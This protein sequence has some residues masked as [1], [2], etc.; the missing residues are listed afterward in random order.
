MHLAAGDGAAAWEAHETA[1]KLTG[2]DPQLA[3][4][5]TFAALAPL[6]GGNLT[7]ARCWADEV[8]SVTK[9][10][11]LAASLTTRSRV[12]LAQ[13]E[14]GAAER[15]AHEALDLTA[16]LKGY[17]LV[18]LAL[19]CLATVAAEY[20]NDQLAARLFGAA[21]AAR[22]Q[23]GVVR[24]KVLDAD[25]EARVTALRDTLGDN[26]FDTAWAEGAALSIEEAIAYA[27]RGRG[28]RARASS[29]WASLTRAELGRGPADQRGSGEQ[30]H[31]RAPVRLAPHRPGPS[32]AHLHQTRADLAGAAR[33]GS[34]AP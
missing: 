20:G 10:W 32:H 15:D 17:L 7:A 13:G 14:I 22:R 8:V 24:F 19:D 2:L 21:D 18:P 26:D 34:V 9:G 16:R 33:A 12:E 23:M 31:C 29:G 3:P 30:G 6:A 28:E 11:S 4:M 25:D 27:Q 5:Y 1:R